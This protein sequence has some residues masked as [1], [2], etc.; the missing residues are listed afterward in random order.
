MVADRLPYRRVLASANPGDVR[1]NF[2]KS[3]RE[4]E[5][6]ALRS[7]SDDSVRLCVCV[8]V[9]YR[10]KVRIGQDPIKF[11]FFALFDGV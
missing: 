7:R 8:Y 9:Q 3:G 10:S 6:V 2:A 4:R 1:C 11:V 5:R